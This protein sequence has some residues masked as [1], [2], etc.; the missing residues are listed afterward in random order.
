MPY[1]HD[2]AFFNSSESFPK[3]KHER[4]TTSMSDKEMAVFYKSKGWVHDESLCSASFAVT[5]NRVCEELGCSVS[6]TVAKV[7]VSNRSHLRLIGVEVK[8]DSKL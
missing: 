6:F 2:W 3:N 8:S 7:I 4:K 5:K 1:S